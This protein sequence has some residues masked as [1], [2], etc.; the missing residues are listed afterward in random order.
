MG[1]AIQKMN[2][3]LPTVSKGAVRFIFSFFMRLVCCLLWNSLIKKNIEACFDREF[4]R[5][6]LQNHMED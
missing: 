5:E 6:G 4:D 1:K 3:N 2:E